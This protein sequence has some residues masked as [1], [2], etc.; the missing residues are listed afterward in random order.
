MPVHFKKH[1]ID[2]EKVLA[3][4]LYALFKSIST[5]RNRCLEQ[6]NVFR[7]LEIG[8]SGRKRAIRPLEI[9]CA[10]AKQCISTPRNGGIGAK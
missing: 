10:G 8:C 7:L 5:H 1:L 4:F 9:D 3:H 2:A 6:N